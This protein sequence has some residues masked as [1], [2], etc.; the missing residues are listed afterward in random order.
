MESGSG[1]RHLGVSGSRSRL[2]EGGG[3]LKDCCSVSSMKKSYQDLLLQYV[4][5]IGTERSVADPGP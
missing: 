4:L 5:Y 3:V 1:S 2:G